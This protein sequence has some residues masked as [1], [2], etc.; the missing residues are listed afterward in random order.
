MM[1]LIQLFVAAA[2]LAA[3]GCGSAERDERCAADANCKAQSST[4]YCELYGWYN[5][6]V[7]DT[8]CGRVDPDCEPIDCAVWT[9][10][11]DYE[12]E[13]ES[14][15]GEACRETT[16]CDGS[17]AKWCDRSAC[18]ET[19]VCEAGFVQREG[20]CVEGEACYQEAACGRYVACVEV[21]V[22][23]DEPVCDD[24]S[25]P[26]SACAHDGE[27]VEIEV[28]D[29]LYYCPP[30]EQCAAV[31][32]CGDGYVEDGTSCQPDTNCYEETVCGA[33]I[34]CRPALGTCQAYP[35]CEEGHNE[36]PFCDVSDATCVQ[37]EVC[38]YTI[39]CQAQCRAIPTCADGYAE[40]TTPCGATDFDCYQESVCGM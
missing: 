2:M 8:F 25:Q 15:E 31:P 36:V 26:T 9:G 10:C 24:G 37:E 14:C 6:G 38:G 39:Y 7:C 11:L 29:T 20:D 23:C 5:D 35:V 34:A 40:D 22:V 32:V 1:R 4:D 17:H 28:C 30:T 16:H 19:P 27:C 13:V 21:P 33:T 3:V 18:L 12:V